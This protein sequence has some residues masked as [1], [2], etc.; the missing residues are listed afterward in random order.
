MKILC[1][2]NNSCALPLFDWLQQKG[3][4]VIL[5]DKRLTENWCRN[6]QI[7]LTVSY[8]YRFILDEK[9][10]FALNDNIV[11][12]HNSLLPWNRGADP[13]LWSILDDAPRGVTLHYVSPGLDKGDIIAQRVVPLST[14]DT[15]KTSYDTLD[16]I[17]QEQF[18]EMFL[19][20]KDWPQMRKRPL[21]EGSYHSVADG[22]ILHQAIDT[23][24]MPIKIFRQRVDQIRARLL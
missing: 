5:C 4:E 23:Y 3:H 2:Y 8:T 21:G 14:D 13:N 11:N 10:I 17:A 15:L 7:D 22:M 20:Y 24:D 12:L 6:R 18:Q 16:K 1:L 9:T 19:W